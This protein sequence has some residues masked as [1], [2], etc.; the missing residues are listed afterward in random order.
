VTQLLLHL[1]GQ[2]ASSQR[3]LKVLLAQTDAI[4]RQDVES[5]LARLS[6]IQG[7]L[8]E[9]ERLERDRDGLL[10]DAATRLGLRAD[11]L[12][13]DDMLAHMPPAEAAVAREKSAE[14]KGLLGE[15]GRV[16]DQNRVLIRQEL[17]FL[18]HLMRLLSGTPQGGYSPKGYTAAAP[19]PALSSLNVRA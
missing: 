11:E 12:T 5:V 16:H 15:V 18:D 4:R 13:L 17:S 8:V 10:R 19:A 2:I 1:D 6:D 7:E 9:R 3:L 14:L